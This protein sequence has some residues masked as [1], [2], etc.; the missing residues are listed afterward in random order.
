MV[1]RNA[2]TQHRF[3]KVRGGRLIQNIQKSQKK[4]FLKKGFLPILVHGDGERVAR[5]LKFLFLIDFVYFLILVYVFEWKRG[6]LSIYSIFF[7]CKFE[8][9]DELQNKWEPGPLPPPCCCYVLVNV[10]NINSKCETYFYKMCNLQI[11]LQ[12]GHRRGFPIHGGNTAKYY[13]R[14][15]DIQHHSYVLVL[16]LAQRVDH[17]KCQLPPQH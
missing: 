13:F 3:W 4:K 9:N 6:T 15:P 2:G 17:T 7:L 10:A 11:H 12:S 8:K 5:Y 14:F 16:F 1:R